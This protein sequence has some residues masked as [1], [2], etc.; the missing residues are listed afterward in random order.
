[1]SQLGFIR[2]KGHR[3]FTYEWVFKLLGHWAWFYRSF[4]RKPSLLSQIVLHRR[5]RWQLGDYQK[6]QLRSL[7][8]GILIFY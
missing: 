7:N 8:S 1:M 3:I 5:L 2:I 4:K 6:P